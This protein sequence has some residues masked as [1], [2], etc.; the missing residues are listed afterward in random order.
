M[1]KRNRWRKPNKSRQSPSLLERINPDVA[2]IDPGSAEHF[3]AVPSDRDPNP[4]QSFHTFT[5]DLERLAEWLAACRVRSVAMEATGVYWIPIFEML[6][7]RGFEV[8]LVNAAAPERPR[9]Q[10]P[11]VVDTSGTFSSR[12]ARNHNTGPPN[13]C[14]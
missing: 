9:N 14:R 3:V 12:S 1:M 10:Q 6:E 5:S 11:G 2:G 7:A 4:V 13:C 8:L